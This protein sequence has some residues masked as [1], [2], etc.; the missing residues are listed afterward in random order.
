MCAGTGPGLAI[1]TSSEVRI[2]ASV[3]A[4]VRGVGDE[5]ALERERTLEPVEQL[6]EGICELQR[7]RGP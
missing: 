4:L 2:P 1:A 5:L 3:C 6:V 7:R